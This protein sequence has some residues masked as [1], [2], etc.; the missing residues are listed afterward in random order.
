MYQALKAVYLE[1]GLDRLREA[2]PSAKEM[3]LEV[4][5]TGIANK[6]HPGAVKFWTEQGVQI[7]DNLK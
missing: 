5:I 3:G 7:P 6:L 4:G 2:H 1:G